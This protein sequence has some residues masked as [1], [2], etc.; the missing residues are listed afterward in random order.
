VIGEGKFDKQEKVEY[1]QGTTNLNQRSIM[2]LY[3]FEDDSF[4]EMPTPPTDNDSDIQSI[5]DGYLV[6][7]RWHD[8][9]VQ[10][11]DPDNGWTNVGGMDK[12]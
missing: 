3:G 10:D 11:Y 5:K 7:F 9:H 6:V 4:V 1:T 8:G 2:Y 12:F